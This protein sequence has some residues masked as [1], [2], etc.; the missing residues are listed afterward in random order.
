MFKSGKL[1]LQKHNIPF[2]WKLLKFFLRDVA[3]LVKHFLCGRREALHSDLEHSVKPG[4]VLNVC[5]LST[6]DEGN[7]RFRSQVVLTC[8]EF[9]PATWVPST[10]KLS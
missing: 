5:D 8:R 9:E 6:G 2:D 3:E 10:N 7:C 4:V 1:S